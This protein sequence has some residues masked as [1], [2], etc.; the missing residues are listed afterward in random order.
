MKIWSG[1]L[2]VG[3]RF[4]MSLTLVLFLRG[5]FN[6]I[7]DSLARILYRAAKLEPSASD[8]GVMGFL[9]PLDV[10]GVAR[11]LCTDYFHYHLGE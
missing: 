11:T 3:H 4:F 6:L 7:Q 2:A 10:D 9:V 1:C 5:Y 8:E